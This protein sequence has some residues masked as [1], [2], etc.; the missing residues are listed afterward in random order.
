MDLMHNSNHGKA[1]KVVFA[2]VFKVKDQKQAIDKDASTLPEDDEAGK[3]TSSVTLMHATLLMN[4]VSCRCG[5]AAGQWWC[6]GA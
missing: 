5:W 6:R 3:A 4:M 2:G 1:C